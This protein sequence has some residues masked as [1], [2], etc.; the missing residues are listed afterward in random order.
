VNGLLPQ[1]AS[2]FVGSV[3]H[4]R[5]GLVPARF[6]YR[7]FMV[8]LDLDRLDEAFDRC[9]IWSHR[10]IAPAWFRRRDHLGAPGSDLAS[11]ARDLVQSRTGHRPEG[12]VLL[13]TNLR[14]A[15]IGMNPVSFYWCLRGDGSSVQAVI[16]E[17]NNT[18]WRERH[19]YVVEP[20]K[21]VSFSKAFHISP[22]QGMAQRYRWRI[23]TP[24]DRLS[25]CMRSDEEGTPVFRASLRMKQLA[26][27][28]ANRSRALLTHPFLTAR[29]LAGIYG[30]ALRLS[31]RGAKFFPHPGRVSAE[32]PTR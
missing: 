13:L 21:S 8:M 9:V 4:A 23:G 30:Q 10:R 32:G 27:T 20:D 26:W 16:A 29:I 3:R 19:C 7:L 1:P 18:P 28:R 17:I 11:C 6:N 25:I 2:L 31:L 12:R 5:L 14:Y 24:T 22:F 15:G